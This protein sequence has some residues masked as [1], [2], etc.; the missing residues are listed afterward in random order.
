MDRSALLHL[1]GPLPA[2]CPLDAATLATVDCG[3]YLRRTVEYAVEA[4]ERV[5]SFVL[6][7]KAMSA[8]AP[9]VYCHHQHASQF[10]LGKSEVVGLAGDPDQA[11]GVELVERG[12]VVIA[13]DAI[14]FEERNWSYLY[15]SYAAG[16]AEYFELASRLVQG[17][18]LLA[19]VLHDVQVALDYLETLPEVDPARFGFIGHSYGGRMAIWA[20]A[21]DDR[22]QASVSNCG[23]IDYKHS[24]ARDTGVQPEFCVPG[25]LQAGDIGDIVRL[26]APRALRMQAALEDKWSLGAEDT[27]AYAL[28]AFPEGQL[29]LRT[30][31]GGHVF[32]ED[33]RRSAYDYLDRHLRA[34]TA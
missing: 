22:I 10:H 28:S 21:F 12:Y 1:I 18:T 5:R 23:C 15:S 17:K 19:K 29:E 13:P 31:P 33:M 14:A 32:T 3:L 24:L 2:R 6:V 9:A 16:H 30:W 26:A 8:P 34:G 20:A 4:G 25:V 7:P 11:Y 27:F